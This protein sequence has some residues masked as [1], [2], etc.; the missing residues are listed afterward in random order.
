M[1]ENK[2]IDKASKWTI[3]FLID[4]RVTFIITYVYVS[5]INLL[6]TTANSEA[7]SDVESNT[8][9]NVTALPQH[10]NVIVSFIDDAVLWNCRNYSVTK[11]YYK[12][13][14]FLLVGALIFTL[15]AFFFTKLA[16]I[17]GSKHGLKHLWR[18]AVVQ[19]ALECKKGQHAGINHCRTPE[20]YRQ[21]LENSNIDDFNIMNRQK[22]FRTFSLIISILLLPIG[23]F[24]AFITY[25]L[26]P[27]SCMLEPG[28]DFIDYDS[29]TET[30]QIQFTDNVVRFQRVMAYLIIVIVITFTLNVVAFFWLNIW[31]VNSL[32]EQV[33]KELCRIAE[34]ERAYCY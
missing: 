6:S 15:K 33:S 23:M 25:D 13:L 14:Y 28:D 34:G 30:V 4:L 18:I 32:K 20:T 22:C 31:I 3:Y 16:I 12:T 26:H 21:L 1:G 7:S 27:I 10:T 19:Y 11:I 17:I 8:R 9:F 5:V 2:E 29:T 24:L